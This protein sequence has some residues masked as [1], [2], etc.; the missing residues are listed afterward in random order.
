MEA[1]QEAQERLTR[2]VINPMRE[3]AGRGTA[4]VE[5]LKAK[6]KQLSSDYAK[7]LKETEKLSKKK[8]GSVMYDDT[9]V[10]LYLDSHPPASYPRPLPAQ[11]R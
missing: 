3:D 9:Y 7:G 1:S 10:R 6:Y 11:A 8:S 5:G 4:M 2:K